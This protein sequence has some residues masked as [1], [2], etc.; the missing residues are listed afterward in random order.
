MRSHWN[1]SYIIQDGSLTSYSTALS[2]TIAIGCSLLILNILIFA[3]V[4]YQRDRNKLGSRYSI[5]SHQT[6][7]PHREHTDISHQQ[8]ASLS[9]PVSHY[10]LYTT[11]H[12]SGH[13]G[14]PPH[15]YLPPPQFADSVTTIDSNTDFNSCNVSTFPR[16][17]HTENSSST[18]SQP[19][20]L[21]TSFKTMPRNLPTHSSKNSFYSISGLGQEMGGG[22]QTLPLKSSLKKSRLAL[23]EFSDR[24]S[25]ADSPESRPNGATDEL[26]V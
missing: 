25:Q 15:N 5:D 11:G 12:N 6:D 10:R 14:H 13:G 16:K 24:D 3:A 23:A 2:V 17:C 19:L 18:E 8:K 4:Y 9:R 7:L 20:M 1:D 22:S 26:R 21:G